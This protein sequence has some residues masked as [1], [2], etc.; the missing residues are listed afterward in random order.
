VTYSSVNVVEGAPE[1]KIELSWP[2]S[3]LDLGVEDPLRRHIGYNPTTDLAEIPE[4]AYSGM[5]VKPEW[6]SI[7]NPEPGEW[8]I[9][10]YGRDVAEGGYELYRIDVPDT[11]PPAAVTDLAT[12]DYTLDSISL[13]WT[14]PGGDG[15]RGTASTYDIRYSTEP[16]TEGNEWDKAFQC[17]GEPT[18]QPAGNMEAFSV[19]GL[20]PSTTYYFAL[21]SA[22]G[23]PNWSR[24]SKCAVGNTVV[25]AKV[26]FDPDTLNLK[27]KGKWVTAY[28]ELPEDYDASK[29]DISSILLNGK[30]PT[31]AKPAE[32][33]DCDS[34]GISDLMVKFDR[35]S[36][37][38]LAGKTIPDDY[39]V[40]VEGLVAGIRFVGIDTIRI[41]SPGKKDK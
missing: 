38:E 23:V 41:I 26:D 33:G 6:V 1:L 15:N 8:K 21:K 11:F 9:Y 40:E 24:L 14:S 16:I 10:V 12:Y 25:I 2:G 28:V 36:V 34:D 32:I 18:P 7:Q 29:I 13:V 31:S 35:A 30:V 3:D 39:V 37:M 17:E 5:D 22:D 19:T 27:S 20:V 4:A